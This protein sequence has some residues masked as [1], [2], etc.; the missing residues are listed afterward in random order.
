MGQMSKPKAPATTSAEWI[1]K[2]GQ[3]YYTGQPRSPVECWTAFPKL[4]K[5]YQRQRW[6]QIMATRLGGQAVPRPVSDIS[7]TKL[8]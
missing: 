5:V 6:A 8:T 7:T 4:A 2:A 1:I 3:R